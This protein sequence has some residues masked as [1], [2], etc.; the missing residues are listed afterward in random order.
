MTLNEYQEK[1]NNT[2]IYSEEYKV[3]YPA[4]GLNGEAGEVAE[5]IK[6]ILRD[7]GGVMSDEN[8]QELAKEIGDALWY[9]AALARDIGVDLNT[10]A[11]MN[12]DKL[13]S[14]KQRNVISGSGDNR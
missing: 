8:K 9:C 6:K 3:I 13:A 5:K 11:Q 7:R 12:I 2:A 4:L 1:A 14:R 10:I